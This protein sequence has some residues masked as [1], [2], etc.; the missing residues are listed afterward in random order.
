MRATFRKK[1]VAALMAAAIAV[2][3]FVSACGSNGGQGESAN[4]KVTLRWSMSA[5]SQAEINVWNHLAKMVTEKYPNIT[6]KFESSPF[7]DYYNKLTT[8]AAGNDLPC[9]AGL[10]NQRVADVGSLYTDLNHYVKDSKFPISQ[11]EPSIVNALKSDGKQLAIP[12]DLGPN[13]MFYN[14]DMF[15]A[16]GLT[17]P[18]A[19]WTREEFLKD[20]KAL[21]KNGKYGYAVSPT[22]WF[23]W[24]LEQG[25][26]YTDGTK[27]TLTDPGMVAGFQTEIDMVK[28][29]QVADAPAASGT[30][31][32]PSDLWRSGQAA[33]VMDGPWSLINARDTV[34]FKVGVTSWPSINGKSIT[35]MSGTG[36]GITKTCKT[37]DAAWKAISVIIGAQAEQYVGQTGRGF[38][39]YRPAQKYWYN[40]AKIDGAQE[41]I[42]AALKDVDNWSTPKG[43][44]QATVLLN[45][46]APEAFT[47]KKS[48]TQVLTTVQQQLGQ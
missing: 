17:E 26:K 31:G 40:T 34:K 11:Y 27:P 29:Y 14:K 23:S 15:K 9:I 37:P 25:G 10:V 35:T 43:W 7:I 5:D 12:Y 30:S 16:A 39:A 46:Y 32:T 20:A 3:G 21:T 44:N 13:I 38:P 47:G 42:E 1:G 6:V 48:A 19:S 33:M 8:Q 4:D 18:G 28:K 22:N 24:A 2:T 36:F 41:A 45:Q